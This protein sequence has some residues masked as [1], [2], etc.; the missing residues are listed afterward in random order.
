MKLKSLCLLALLALG[1]MAS[2]DDGYY[3]DEVTEQ[4]QPMFDEH[5]MDPRVERPDPRDIATSDEAEGSGDA[6]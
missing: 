4:S 5:E 2:A 6:V 1:S 3:E